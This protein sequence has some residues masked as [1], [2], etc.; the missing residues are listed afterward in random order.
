MNKRDVYA[1]ILMVA[2]GTFAAIYGHGYPYGSITRLGPGF[3]PFWLGI[4]LAVIGLVIAAAALLA[5]AVESGHRPPVPDL[6]AAA[7]IIAALLLFVF[8]AGRFGLVP[9][10]FVLVLVSALGDRNQTWKG[11]S[12]LA[13]LVTAAGVGLFS[14]A[15]GLPFRLFIWDAS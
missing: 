11:A 13:L 7:C 9:A 6:R 4:I 3:V 12:L 8:L 2:I 1:G 5:S 10:S 14:Y 15:L